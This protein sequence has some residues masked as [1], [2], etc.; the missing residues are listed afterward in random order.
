MTSILEAIQKNIEY[1]ETELASLR[2]ARDVVAR[3]QNVPIKAA[4]SEGVAADRVGSPAFVVTRT[5]PKAGAVKVRHNRTELRQRIINLMTDC[6]GRSAS[7]VTSQLNI[8][9]KDEQA[10]TWRILTKLKSAGVLVYDN[11]NY[12]MPA[13]VA[14]LERA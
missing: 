14:D 12:L 1:H 10:A 9:A 5:K 8:T 7:L 2:T 4:Q 11:G 6:H 13:A 3:L